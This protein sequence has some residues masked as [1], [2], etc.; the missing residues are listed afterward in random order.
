MLNPKKVDTFLNSPIFFCKKQ[1]FCEKNKYQNS[2]RKLK[3]SG[4]LGFQGA[5]KAS[6]KPALNTCAL[7]P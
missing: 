6:K 2:R 4:F 7:Q 5:E 1:M 3:K